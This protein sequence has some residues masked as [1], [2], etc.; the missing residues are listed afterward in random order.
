MR[1]RL[2]ILTVFAAF[3]LSFIQ[4]GC[5]APASPDARRGGGEQQARLRRV[6][7]PPVPPKIAE[8]IRAPEAEIAKAAPK[9]VFE[10]TVHDF[11]QIDPGTRHRCEFKF[12]NAGIALLK[13]GKVRAPCGCTI[14]ELKKKR[15]EPGE[16]GMLKVQYHAST[17]PG[18]A[19]KYIFV[20][21]NDPENPEVKLSIKSKVVEKV[22]IKP[23]RLN[24]SLRKE[25]AGCPKITITSTDGQPF[26][27]RKFESPGNCITADFNPDE[28]A[29]EFVL[30]PKVDTPKLRKML[31]GSIRIQITHP[32]V[33]RLTVT[34]SAPPDF[35]TRP[36]TIFIQRAKSNKPIQRKIW[37][38]SNY[39]EDF[40]IESISSQKGSI[41]VLNR[42]KQ[43]GQFE[44]DI[45]IT[46]PE[47]VGKLKF[48]RDVIKIKIKDG[49]TIET[50]CSI[51][52]PKKAK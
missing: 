49:P 12:K 5:P 43:A 36:Q 15:Y 2:T 40:E 48:F 37:I 31:N 17:K 28:K 50:N 30:Q 20:P 35:Q 25:N 18:P 9:I 24:L 14:P 19:T 32:K 3:G 27:I 10:N 26:S 44:L 7:K 52:Y 51:W 23:K 29:T 45:E 4:V 8:E 1:T 6:E 16:T 38:K 33:N 47:P 22:S 42:N 46:P 13:I 41:K 34:Y 21:S 39:N 11:G